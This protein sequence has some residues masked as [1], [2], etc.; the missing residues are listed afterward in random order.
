MLVTIPKVQCPKS[1][2]DLKLIN[3]WNFNV[4]VIF[5]F[6]AARLTPILP[7][8]ILVEHSSFTKT[9]SISDNIL[10]AQEQI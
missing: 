4:K 8:I 2:G 9:R 6:L 10:L 3:L 7:L 1:F 5:K